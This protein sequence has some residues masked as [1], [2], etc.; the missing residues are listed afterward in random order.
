MKLS[1]LLIKN[2]AYSL[3]DEVKVYYPGGYMCYTV[4]DL[5]DHIRDGL[6]D[7][8]EVCH[9]FLYTI[10]CDDYVSR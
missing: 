3:Y 9:F 10:Y 1:E 7:D 6:E 4:S 5:L 8:L 2:S